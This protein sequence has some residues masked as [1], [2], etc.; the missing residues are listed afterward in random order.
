MSSNRRAWM[1]G[2]AAVFAVSCLVTTP[3]G[4]ASAVESQD[5]ASRSTAGPADF[6]PFDQPTPPYT[7][8][9]C[10]LPLDGDDGQSYTQ[11]PG[12]GA[13]VKVRAG[14]FH[15]GMTQRSVPADGWEQWGSPP[16]TED[17]TPRILTTQKNSVRISFNKAA[18]TGGVEIEPRGSGTH[19]F[20]VYF[21]SGQNG[22]GGT[23]GVITR[24]VT[25][26]GGAKLFGATSSATF[27]SIVIVPNDNADFAVAQIRL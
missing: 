8:N 27:Q 16:D 2:L 12:C 22:A 13:V 5:F 23:V 19:S 17:S 26:D 25:A 1:Q 14:T 18:T 24:D 4:A 3:L 21:T 9:S 11:I 6:T 7:S 10:V 20:S 15:H